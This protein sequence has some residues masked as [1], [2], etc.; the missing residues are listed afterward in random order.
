MEFYLSFFFYRVFCHSI[1]IMHP[2]EIGGVQ[3]SLFDF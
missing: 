1:N 2:F 3:S